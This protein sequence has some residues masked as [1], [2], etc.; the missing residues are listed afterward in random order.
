MSAIR[1][2]NLI[3]EVPNKRILNDITLEINQGEVVSIMGG[4]GSGKTSLLRMMSGLRRP[5]SGEIWIDN[6]NIA[7]MD[8]H[9]LDERRLKI[10]LVFQYAALFDSL[11]VYDNIVFSL[12]R[13]NRKL[14]REQL[15]QVVRDR[16][17]QVQLEGTEHLFPSELSGGMQKRIGLARALATEPSL[18]FYDEPT[19][20]LDPLTARAIDDLI[21]E[22]RKRNGVTS[23]VVSH[24]IPSIFRISDRIAMIAEGEIVIFDTPDAVRKSDNPTVRE[25]IAPDLEK[26]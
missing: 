10:G 18:V 24:H 17:A 19:S 8:D 1:V 6:E 11:D 20:G 4:S 21:L 12:T 22:T 3:Y 23:V 16:L 2:K 5:T 14:K 15:D 25:F 13:H 7:A 9:E 26:G